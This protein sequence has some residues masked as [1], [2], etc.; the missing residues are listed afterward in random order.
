[1]HKP[2]A[3]SPAASSAALGQGPSSAPSAEK[4]NLH[5]VPDRKG[6]TGIFIYFDVSTSRPDSLHY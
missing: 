4:C 1:M 5:L 3:L 2:E 6:H